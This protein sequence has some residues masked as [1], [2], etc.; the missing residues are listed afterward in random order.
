MNEMF[1]INNCGEENKYLVIEFSDILVKCLQFLHFW[2]ERKADKK[3]IV[4]LLKLITHTITNSSD[5]I[6]RKSLQVQNYSRYF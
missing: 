2:K 1:E 5:E 4:H 6:K 3:N